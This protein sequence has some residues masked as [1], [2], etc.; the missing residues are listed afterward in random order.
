[1]LTRVLGSMQA[2]ETEDGRLMHH[3]LYRPVLEGEPIDGE[4]RGN[5]RFHWEEYLTPQ[6]M[7]AL[8][9]EQREVLMLGESFEID[10]VSTATVVS[11]LSLTRLTPTIAD[12]CTTASVR[13][14]WAACG[15]GRGSSSRRSLPRATRPGCEARWGAVCVCA[16]I[17]V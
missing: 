7:A 5:H 9:P 6:L 11:H 12:R 4:H 10:P 2:N 1:M 17:S 16:T 8:S 14:N 13:R 15:G 3:W